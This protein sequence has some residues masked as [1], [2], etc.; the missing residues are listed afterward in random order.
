MIMVESAF[1][2]TPTT[3]KNVSLLVAEMVARGKT[4]IEVN[5]DSMGGD[6]DV[7]VVKQFAISYLEDGKSKIRIVPEGS[8]LDLM[9]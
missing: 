8:S 5:N 3:G 4:T 6:P 2:G 9:K 1:Y 7:G